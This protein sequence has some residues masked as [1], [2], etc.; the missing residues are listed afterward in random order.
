MTS[1]DASSLDVWNSAPPSSLQP[2]SL[3][4]LNSPEV[5]EILESQREWDAT[6]RE[7]QT[8]V[9]AIEE[10]EELDEKG[11]DPYFSDFE[12]MKDRWDTETSLDEKPM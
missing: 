4:I 8:V 11:G 5:R 6:L 3:D 12:A 9:W 7:E 1:V 2:E 10:E